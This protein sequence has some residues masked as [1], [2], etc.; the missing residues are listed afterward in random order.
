MAS[1]WKETIRGCEK[2]LGNREAVITYK[3]A[4]ENC[5]DALHL[6]SET[7]DDTLGPWSPLMTACYDALKK[8]EK[9]CRKDV[10]EDYEFCK[11]A[12]EFCT[13]AFEDNSWCYL[14]D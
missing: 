4:L 12:Y 2:V 14:E 1:E 13:K 3:K 6:E 10:T 9:V 5:V 7:L 11:R 8:C